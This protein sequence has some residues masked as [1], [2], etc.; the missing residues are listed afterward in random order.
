M[1]QHIPFQK[2]QY[3]T[4]K[5]FLTAGDDS[6]VLFEDAVIEVYLTADGK[7]RVRGSGLIRPFLMVQLMEEKE[8]IDLMID[9]GGAFKFVMKDP[10]LQSGKVFSPDV[11]ATVLFYPSRPWVQMDEGEFEE[12]YKRVTF[13]AE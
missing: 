1:E 2:G 5:A 6:A 8:E 12:L 4:E 11:V 9:L 3:L 10:V 7:R 13:I